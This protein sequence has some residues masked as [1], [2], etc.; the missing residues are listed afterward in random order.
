MNDELTVNSTIF[1]DIPWLASAAK[2]VKTMKERIL[3]KGEQRRERRESK[4]RMR[5]AP[6]RRRRRMRA[7]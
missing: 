7:S 4:G 1:G 5:P 2:R 6:V 3:T